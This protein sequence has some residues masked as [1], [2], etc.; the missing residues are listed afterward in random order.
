MKKCQTEREFLVKPQNKQKKSLILNKKLK[1]LISKV[2]KVPKILLNIPFNYSMIND[3][4][5]QRGFSKNMI[6]NDAYTISNIENTNPNY[7]F[8][9]LSNS[10]RTKIYQKKKIQIPEKF[11]DTKE[12]IDKINSFSLKK[13]LSKKS[14]EK[15]KKFK[16]FKSTKNNTFINADSQKYLLNNSKISHKIKKYLNSNFF[17]DR[18]NTINEGIKEE[19]KIKTSRYKRIN[20]NNININLNSINKI[21]NKIDFGD[22]SGNLNTSRSNN[23]KIKDIQF[24][25]KLNFDQPTLKNFEQNYK[26]IMNKNNKE[27]KSNEMLLNNQNKILNRIKHKQ[28]VIY[29]NCE[30]N[31]KNSLKNKKINKI[32]SKVKNSLFIID[33]N[34]KQSKSFKKSLNYSKIATSNTKINNSNKAINSNINIKNKKAE[35]L[36]SNLITSES[37]TILD[38][39]VSEFNSFINQSKNISRSESEKDEKHTVVSTHQINL[40][41]NKAKKSF[42]HLKPINKINNFG[43]KIMNLVLKE[44]KVEFKNIFFS[45]IN[46]NFKLLLIKF[47]DK[48][49]LLFLSSVNKNFYFNLR[50]KIY[51]YF[52]DKII[53]NNGNRDHI[54]KILYSV[55]KYA[56]KSLKFNNANSLKAKYEYYKRCKSKYDIIITQDISRT[57]PNE[58]NFCVNSINYKKLYNIL[59]AYSNFNKS[60]GYAQGLNF[61]TA[62]AIILFKSE[63]KIFLFLD[64]L[65]N[66]FNLE[67]F[68]S[69]N[70]QKLPK[71]IKYLSQ[72]LNKYCK[73]FI[74]YLKSKFINHDF[75]TTSWLLTLFSNSMDRKK[76]Y[77]CWCFMIIFGWKFFYSFIIQIILFYENRLMKIN[78]GKL[79]KQ[80]KE[81]LKSNVFIKDFNII[82]KNTLD[83]ME[84]NIVL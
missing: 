58:A 68:L 2:P 52:Y 27:Y 46:T 56:S 51:K 37:L 31:Q 19:K 13:N 41:L 24:L 21:T 66:R 76:L 77:I 54:L 29:K 33:K 75:F 82:M 55:Q 72:I 3:K 7:L 1:M 32:Q 57:F 63:E 35:N 70:N 67:Y 5:S 10:H 12:E 49:S 74:N 71:Q 9:S 64:G 59:T 50:K 30:S 39:S 6:S 83:F 15:P 60:I 69:I 14:N 47:L 65:I 73:N 28:N 26:T 81:L 8:N 61:L 20:I 18:N 40:Y 78:E 34:K 25:K 23:S 48:K 36:E 43:N 17:F 38:N 22:M 45:S 53:K 4:K 16:S 79:S 80:M 62:R 42:M 84:K 11:N 44:K